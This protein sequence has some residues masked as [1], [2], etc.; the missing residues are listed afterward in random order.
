MGFTAKLFL[1]YLLLGAG[2]VIAQKRKQKAIG[3]ALIL[4]IAASL[5]ILGYLWITSPM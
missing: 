2:A 3:T 4:V 1:A 5:L